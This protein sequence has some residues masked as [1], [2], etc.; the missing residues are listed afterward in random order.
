MLLARPT[1]LLADDD[2][3]AREPLASALRASGLPVL[4]ADTAAEALE[5]LRRRPVDVLV[6]DI[7]MPGNE[8]LQLLNSPL[9]LDRQVAVILI[10]GHASLDTA[11]K[12]LRAKVA[13][14]LSKPFDVPTLLTRIDAAARDRQSVLLTSQLASVAQSLSALDDTPASDA[15][16]QALHHLDKL[17]SREREVASLLVDGLKTEEVANQLFISP[18]TVRNHLRAI[19]KKLSV[20][21]HADLMLK[22][23]RG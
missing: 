6:S 3:L 22:L 2:P 7:N 5:V 15:R 10:T 23:I 1:V 8:E 11:V 19:F 21:S 4:T 9:V 17:S 20:S 12:A 18:F 16:T 13:D 14:Y